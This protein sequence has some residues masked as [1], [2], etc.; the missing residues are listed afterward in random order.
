MPWERAGG[1]LSLRRERKAKRLNT[2]IW[3][4]LRR[5]RDVRSK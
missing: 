1:G 5:L 2:C 3:L 4:E